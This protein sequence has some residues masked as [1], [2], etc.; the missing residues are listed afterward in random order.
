MGRADHTPRPAAACGI[1]WGRGGHG[2][3][4]HESKFGGGKGKHWLDWTHWSQGELTK[5]SISSRTLER[6]RRPRWQEFFAACVF[7]RDLSTCS[8]FHQISFAG[9]S[10]Q[11][12]RGRQS[13]CRSVDIP[14][15][16]NSSGQARRGCVCLSQRATGGPRREIDA[17][18]TRW[19]LLDPLL[20]SLPSCC[21][22]LKLPNWKREATDAKWRGSGGIP[23]WWPMVTRPDRPGQARPH[24]FDTR[25]YPP[26]WCG[27]IA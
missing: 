22:L 18:P 20:S 21:P 7:P 24:A 14:A 26:L 17:P 25:A 8:S 6:W 9:S 4:E 5:G 2:R 3:R 13:T 10:R 19:Q 23:W 27:I 11:T 15:T 1:S 12:Q 16:A